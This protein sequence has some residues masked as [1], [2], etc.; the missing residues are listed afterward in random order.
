MAEWQCDREAAYRKLE[1]LK[2]YLRELGSVAVAF[3]GGV[4]STFLLKAAKETLGSQARAVTVC[5]GTF[6][7]RERKEAE[8]FC[9]GEGIPQMICPVNELEIPGFSQNPPNRCYLCKKEIFRNILKIARE[10]GIS[11]VAEG[12]NV[13]DEGDY[14]PGMKAIAELNIKSPLREVGLT[15]EE[16]RLLSEEYGLPTWNKPSFACLS[17]R[18]VYG[19]RITRE[20][21]RMVE[22]AEQLLWEMGFSKMRVRI[23]GDLARIEVAPEEFLG[24]LAEE[25]R[26]QITTRFREYGFSYVTMDLLGYRMGSMNEVLKK[27]GKEKAEM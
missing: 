14:R 20:K 7:E 24:L 2:Q 8:S 5:S 18:F 15:K 9:Q 16:I 25:N 4:D 26:E 23:H 6:P 3:S 21:L 1:A 27:A 11:H 13:D 10:H 22:Q 17:S 12:S 19:E